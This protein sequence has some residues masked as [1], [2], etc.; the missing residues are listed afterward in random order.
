MVFWEPTRHVSHGAGEGP[1][2]WWVPG[3]GVGEG[4]R[5]RGRGTVREG[6]RERETACQAALL[7]KSVRL[8]AM[9][10]AGP[11]SLADE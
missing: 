1:P 7:L 10:S 5:E 9:L 3:S 6:E 2:L 8:S 4:G 11:G